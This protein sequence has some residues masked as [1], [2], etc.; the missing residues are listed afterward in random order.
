MKPTWLIE[1]DVFDNEIQLYDEIKKQ[2]MDVKFLEYDHLR[3]S[4]IDEMV[5]HPHEWD[6]ECVVFYG[7]LNLG[8]K[9]RKTPW[10][11]GV[12]LDEKSFECTS[13]YPVLGDSL[14]HN[15]YL[16]LPFGDLNRMKPYLFGHFFKNQDKLFIRPNSG[17]KEFTGMV[18]EKDK[19]EEGIKLAGFYNIDPDM[20][21][22]VSNVWNLLREWR[23]VVVDKKIVTGSAYRAWTYGEKLDI[24]T[25]DYVLQRSHSIKEEIFENPEFIGWDKDAWNVAQVCANKYKPYMDDCWTIDVAKS[26]HGEYSILEIGSFSCASLYG[27]NLEKV[28]KSVSATALRVWKEESE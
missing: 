10:I 25:T 7:S 18:I 21:V 19:W 14:V 2:G 17:M 6:P 13:Y 20:L 24:P 16:M 4:M 1:K 23:F 26:I 22:L 5:N 11:P 28:V 27:A 3:P 8:R 15:K 9:I 12:Y